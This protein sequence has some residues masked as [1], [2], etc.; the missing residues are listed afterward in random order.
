MMKV[1]LPACIGVNKVLQDRNG[2]KQQN[3]NHLH[4]RKAGLGSAQ[5]LVGTPD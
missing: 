2:K 5:S 4:V 3:R 1:G